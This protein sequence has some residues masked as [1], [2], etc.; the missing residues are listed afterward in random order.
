V[1]K[2][3]KGVVQHL[4]CGGMLDTRKTIA[5]RIERVPLSDILTYICDGS[6]VDIGGAWQGFGCVQIRICLS[7]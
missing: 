7:A 2:L 3:T 5:P 4:P 6:V 1:E